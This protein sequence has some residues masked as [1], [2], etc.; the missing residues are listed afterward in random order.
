VIWRVRVIRSAFIRIGGHALGQRRYTLKSL[1]IVVAALGAGVAA[2]AR[3]SKGWAVVLTTLLL[4]FLLT[5]LI[6]ILLQRGPRW[7]FWFGYALFGW[8]YLAPLVFGK[9]DFPSPLSLDH[10]VNGPLFGLLEILVIL[11]MGD[12]E[13][14]AILDALGQVDDE[15]RFVVAFSV[16]GLLFASFGGL[17]ARRLSRNDPPSTVTERSG[18]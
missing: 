5:S 18:P 2:L 12:K 3:P 1:M 9:D 11:G 10:L 14:I 15:S 7:A 16:L 6:G 8:A 4:T 17:I 13:P